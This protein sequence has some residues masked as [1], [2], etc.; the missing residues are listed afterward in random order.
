[1]PNIK[2]EPTPQDSQGL[3]TSFTCK[4]YKQIYKLNYKLIIANL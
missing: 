1:M 3:W 4:Y 2:T